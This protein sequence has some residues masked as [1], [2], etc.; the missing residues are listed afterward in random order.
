MGSTPTFGNCCQRRNERDYFVIH[1]SGT[2]FDICRL[3]S[4]IKDSFLGVVKNLSSA[5]A[6]SE[7]NIEP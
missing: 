4:K 1:K 2:Q 5:E 7:N 3:S 6:L